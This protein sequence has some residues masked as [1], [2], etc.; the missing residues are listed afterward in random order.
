MKKGAKKLPFLWLKN[1][2]LSIPF[3]AFRHIATRLFRLGRERAVGIPAR[4]GL[5]EARLDELPL[6]VLVVAEPA[7]FSVLVLDYGKE[8]AAAVHV[9]TPDLMVTF[10]R[11]GVNGAA[12]GDKGNRVRG[13]SFIVE[14][15]RAR[16]DSNPRPSDS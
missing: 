15:W 8:P 6:L 10:M 16:R 5:K 7:L 2:R 9:K 13:M 11:T 14:N 4:A 3:F 1:L 12:P